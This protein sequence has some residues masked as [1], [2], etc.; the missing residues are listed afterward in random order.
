MVYSVSPS[1]EYGK[2]YPDHLFVD[3][4]ETDRKRVF[5]KPSPEISSGPEPGS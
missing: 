1:F 3:R 4:L 2:A 5:A